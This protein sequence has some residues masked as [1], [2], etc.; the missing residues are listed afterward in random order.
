[1]RL[2]RL[3]E[4]PDRASTE[5]LWAVLGGSMEHE[6]LELKSR[7][8]DG[9]HDVFA[10]MAMTDGGLVLLGVDDKTRAIVGCPLTQQVYDAVKRASHAVGVDV[11]LGEVEVD[12][13]TVTVIAVP[14][15]RE[16]IVTTPNGRLLRRVGS[17]NQPLVGDALGHFVSAR[18]QRAADEQPLPLFDVREVNLDLVNRALA[19]DGR[20]RTTR[21]GV[22]R[23]LVDLGC[24]TPLGPA[25]DPAVMVATALLFA[26]T[27]ERYVSGARVQLVRRVG[28]GPEPGAT[29]DRHE[30]TGPIPVLVQRAIDFVD[31]HTPATEV[32]S[33]RQRERVPAYPAT[34]LREAVVNALAHRD[35]GLAGATVDVTVWDDR[36]EIKSPGGLPGHVTVQNIRDEHFSRNRIVMRTLKLLGLVEEYGEG[37][38]RMF[39]DMEER[40]LQPPTFAATPASVSVTLKS[41]SRLSVED[42]VW[43]QLL[44]RPNLS[45]AERLALVA[46]RHRGDITRKRAAA[47]I[48]EGEGETLLRALVAKGLLRQVG[49]R[50]GSRYVL[51]PEALLR[52]GSTGIEARS[53]R[54]ERLLDELRRRGSLSVN[55]G[56]AIVDGDS[57]LARDLLREFVLAGLARAEG[58]TSARRYFP[59]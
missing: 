30:V 24:A 27:P 49:T 58:N 5:D 56:A 26:K 9:L 42:Q 17:D 16:R 7:P 21:Q 55:E 48:D 22:L 1:M 54:R 38:D 59:I 44:G 45:T 34:V 43:L 20:P 46:V 19:S 10:A 3:S 50:G 6:R 23:A 8:N 39:R 15:V 2:P 53:R 40:L 11:Q 29:V 14:D 12:G 31:K 51:T 33:G 41:Q 57:A 52:A 37:V 28:V 36:V 18:L 25:G 47:F 35:Y 13:L 32:V 4:L